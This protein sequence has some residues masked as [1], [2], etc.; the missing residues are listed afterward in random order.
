MSKTI[1]FHPSYGYATPEQIE[2]LKQLKLGA[3]Y[4]SLLKKIEKQ[5]KAKG[6]IKWPSQ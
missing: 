3:D 2:K 1:P 4:Q 5:T 6:K